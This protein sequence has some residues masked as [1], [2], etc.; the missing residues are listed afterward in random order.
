M[1]KITNDK[2]ITADNRSTMEGDFISGNRMNV[3][4]TTK[5]LTGGRQKKRLIF[6][7]CA[8]VFVAVASILLFYGC[9]KEDVQTGLVKQQEKQEMRSM[10]SCSTV[11]PIGIITVSEGGEIPCTRVLVN[12]VWNE[13]LHRNTAF[14]H[15]TEIYKCDAVDVLTSV[16]LV[17][18]IK[19]Q[20]LNLPNIG[21]DYT[22]IN[23]FII[24]VDGQ[25]VT[26]DFSYE[27][28]FE[29]ADHTVTGTVLVTYANVVSVWGEVSS[30]I[31]WSTVIIVHGVNIV[32]LAESQPFNGFYET[33]IAY[34]NNWCDYTA[35]ELAR[36]EELA[37]LMQEIIELGIYDSVE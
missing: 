13:E 31:D 29:Y 26:P 33:V 7:A 23:N 4:L 10:L 17:A 30:Q 24:R 12:K 6:G 2:E 8:T 18:E 36:M 21:I 32:K 9:K 16:E 19:P 15:K 28:P 1:S 35:E 3:L 22:N 20:V 11:N 5:R 14:S 27:K 25:V 37:K 34:H